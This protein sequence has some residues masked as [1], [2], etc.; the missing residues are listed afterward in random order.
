M[1]RVPAGGHRLGRPRPATWSASAFP[2]PGTA[3]PASAALAPA[4]EHDAGMSGATRSEKGLR[5]EDEARRYLEA[6]GW[7][8]LATRWRCRFGELD[9]VARDDRTLVFVEVRSRGS[10]RCG[11]PE[12]TIGW[13]KRQRLI[14]AVGCW[15]IGHGGVG[16]THCRFDV[17]AISRHASGPQPGE[18]MRRAPVRP[19]RPAL[20]HIRDAFRLDGV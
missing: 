1:G 7:R 14:R 2:R 19:D 17:I 3:A 10:S 11:Y 12:E 15:L 5:G 20:L 9:I 6:M 18:D 8:I 4:G 16:N 13:T